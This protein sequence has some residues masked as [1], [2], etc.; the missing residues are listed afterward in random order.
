MLVR[1]DCL[2]G[3]FSGRKNTISYCLIKFEIIRLIPI[4]L[5]RIYIDGLWTL[6]QLYLTCDIWSP[7]FCESSCCNTL[8]ETSILLILVD[9]DD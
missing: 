1:K 9:V 8:K 4:L 2:K 7:L 5:K 3:E 6:E